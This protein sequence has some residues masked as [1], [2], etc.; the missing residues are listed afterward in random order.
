MKYS[1]YRDDVL[2]GVSINYIFL[3]FNFKIHSYYDI[4][5]LTVPK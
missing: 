2:K 4:L 5:R 1:S 3:N